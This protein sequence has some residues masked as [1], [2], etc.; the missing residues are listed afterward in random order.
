M[1][2]TAFVL[3]GGALSGD[4][5][6][7]ALKLLYAYGYRPDVICGTSVGSLNGVRLAEGEGSMQQLEQIWRGLKSASQIYEVNPQTQGFLDNFSQNAEEIVSFLLENATGFYVFDPLVKL[8]QQDFNPSLVQSSG[9]KLRLVSISMMTGETLV[10]TETGAVSRSGFV[11]NSVG[12]SSSKDYLPNEPPASTVDPT[13][14]ALGDAVI[15]SSSVPVINTPFID[16]TANNEYRVDGGIRHILPVNALLDTIG[17]GNRALPANS[18]TFAVLATPRGEGSWN[19][20]PDGSTMGFCTLFKILDRMLLTLVDEITTRDIGDLFASAYLNNASV[21]LIDPQVAVHDPMNIDPDLVVSNIDY[22][23]NRAADVLLGASQPA[24][25]SLGLGP[26]ATMADVTN[27]LA[28]IDIEFCNR[29]HFSLGAGTPE[30]SSWANDLMV[31]AHTLSK[32]PSY[33]SNEY[34]AADLNWALSQIATVQTLVN[35]RVAVLLPT[36][37]LV[38]ELTAL[39]SDWPYATNPMPA[40]IGVGRKSVDLGSILFNSPLPNGVGQVAIG[41]IGDQPVTVNLAFAGQ[42][43]AQFLIQPTGAASGSQAQITLGRRTSVLVQVHPQFTQPGDF[44]AILNLTGPAGST[45][46]GVPAQVTLHASVTARPASIL[47][48]PSPLDFGQVAPGRAKQTKVITISNAGSAL[49]SV[50]LADIEN[51]TGTVDAGPFTTNPVAGTPAGQLTINPLQSAQ[52]SVT[53]TP[54]S[55]NGSQVRNLRL[56]TN[57]PSHATMLVG[58]SAL[59][60][61]K[62]PKEVEK[63]PKESKDKDKAE[64]LKEKEVGAGKFSSSAQGFQA[65]GEGTSGDASAFIRPEERP[66]VER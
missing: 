58:L 12:V 24:P 63:S 44:N 37:S 56:K 33:K 28:G 66:N 14:M 54:P 18:T 48:S 13:T 45:I 4:F 6:C 51:T 2:T 31:E 36:E 53:F 25:A 11:V 21:R 49:L 52:V 39:W 17:D 60:G 22:G 10:I 16:S 61:T 40:R 41:N 26:N 5:E 1:S 46:A 35:T 27:A 43:P 50:T 19:P 7:G 20:T 29:S 3:S 38:H 32:N 15:A 64:K 42:N 65:T 34:A 57:D 47:V 62:A 55:T 59:V 30:T 9:I 23:F 8:I